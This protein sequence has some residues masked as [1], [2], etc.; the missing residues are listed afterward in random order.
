MFYANCRFSGTDIRTAGDVLSAHL[1]SI[2]IIIVWCDLFDGD[3]HLSHQEAG[4]HVLRDPLSQLVGETQFVVPDIRL[5]A[6]VG[7]VLRKLIDQFPQQQVV[8]GYDAV[9]LQA[10]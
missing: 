3:S 1:R 5:K 2:V 8:R 6:V 7:D 4:I 9:C 10:D